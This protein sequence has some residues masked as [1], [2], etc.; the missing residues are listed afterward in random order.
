MHWLLATWSCRS[1]KISCAN[2]PLSRNWYTYICNLVSI[3]C[4]P[5]MS[6]LVYSRQSH[7][8]TTL[9]SAQRVA[10]SAAV[11][12]VTTVMCVFVPWAVQFQTASLVNV[13]S[14]KSRLSSSRAVLT[15]TSLCLAVHTRTSWAVSRT[16]SSGSVSGKQMVRAA[17]VVLIRCTT[18]GG[19]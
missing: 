11:S 5:L 6:V 8:H 12:S 13:V 19:T 9:T 14:W 10:G 3:T 15:A 17:R 1:T 2:T 18:L 4:W 7:L 16:K